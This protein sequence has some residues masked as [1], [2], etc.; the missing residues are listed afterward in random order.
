MADRVLTAVRVRPLNE[1]E[2]RSNCCITVNIDENCTEGSLIIVDPAF[3]QKN[4]ADRR[5]YERQFNLDYSFWSA[6]PQKNFAD[7]REV[8]EKCGAPLIKHC[9]DGLNCSII[10]YGQT[11][12]GKVGDTTT[13]REHIVIYKQCIW[14]IF[15]FSIDWILFCG[16]N[17][18]I[19]YSLSRQSFLRFLYY[20]ISFA[21][22]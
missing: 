15:G 22:S 9:M 2:I 12:S 4:A 6:S 7:Q 17:D 8:F 20:F 16:S 3:Y 18:D 5:P 10:A 14:S 1:K 19:I 13:L 21:P 11:G